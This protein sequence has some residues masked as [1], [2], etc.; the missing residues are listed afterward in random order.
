[1]IRA[2]GDAEIV[3]CVQVLVPVEA[4]SL[5]GGPALVDSGSRLLR[6][7]SPALTVAHFF[8]QLGFGQRTTSFRIACSPV[9]LPYWVERRGSIRGRQ[10]PGISATWPSTHILANDR[11]PLAN[12]HWE[13]GETA[14]LGKMG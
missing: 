7:A 3:T 9:L 11:I 12:N 1:M 6:H 10:T 5:T 13:T 8:R 2:G 14:A 4:F